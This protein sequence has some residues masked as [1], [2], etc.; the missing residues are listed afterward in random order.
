MAAQPCEY[1]ETTAVYFKGVHFRN[2][3]DTSIKITKNPALGHRKLGGE[4][5]A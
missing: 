3:I 5:S 4:S 2:V 1:T